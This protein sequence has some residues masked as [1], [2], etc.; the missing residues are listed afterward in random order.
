LVATGA[1]VRGLDRGYIPYGEDISQIRGRIDFSVSTRRMLFRQA[2]AFCV[3]D[4]FT[5]DVLNNQILKGTLRKLLTSKFLDSRERKQLKALL[6]ALSGVSDIP[7]DAKS[8]RLVQLHSN[9]ANYRFLI[10]LCQLIHWSAIPGENGNDLLFRDFTRDVH[11]M[12][13]LFESFV[14]NY[15]RRHLPSSFAVHASGKKVDW[16][17][18]SASASDEAVLP[19]MMTDI[20][21]SAPGRR[22]IVDTKFTP[23][24]YQKHHQ[25]GKTLRSSHLYQIRTYMREAHLE[26]AIGSFYSEQSIEGMLLYPAVSDPIRHEFEFGTERLR[27]CTLNLAADYIDVGRE[28]LSLFTVDPNAEDIQ[29]VA[30]AAFTS[31]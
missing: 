19:K 9:N 30:L 28:L 10:Q 23:K 22:I 21:V 20:S 11:K 26:S 12:R 31:H 29:Q 14:R 2:R 4:E 27:V 6:P 7:L 8:F 13:S 18:T 1:A 17:L 3:Y 25:G 15:L 16:G 5:Y 24:I